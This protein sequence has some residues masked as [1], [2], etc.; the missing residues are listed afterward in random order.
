M[1][2]LIALGLMSLTSITLPGL[3]TKADAYCVAVDANVQ[4]ALRGSQEP[5]HQENN[6]GMVATPDCYGNVS[7]SVNSS[8]AAG[9]SVSQTRNSLH[10]LEGGAEQNPGIDSQTRF[11]QVNHQVDIYVPIY[12]PEYLER[13]GVDP[14]VVNQY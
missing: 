10:L 5:S 11:H 7:T 13:M 14:G 1:K 3:T 4:V 8:V 6:V 9:E 2:S 12:D